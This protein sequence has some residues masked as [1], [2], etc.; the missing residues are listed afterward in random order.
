MTIYVAGKKQDLIGN[1]SF[2]T[3]DETNGEEMTFSS[4]K[5]FKNGSIIKVTDN[6][7][8][9]FLGTIVRMTDPEKPPYDYTA[10]DFSRSLN[11]DC[12]I[13]FKGVRADEALKSL[14]KKYGIKCSVSV[15]AAVSRP[16]AFH[17]YFVDK[18]SYSI[19]HGIFVGDVV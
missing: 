3:N 4:L 11:G 6:K 10:I 8:V 12:L 7:A 13:Q 17:F 19:S 16:F 2:T 14:F 15:D 18:L 5:K 1:V 9:Q